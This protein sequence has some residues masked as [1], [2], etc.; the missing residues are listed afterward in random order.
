MG[1]TGTDRGSVSKRERL[2]DIILECEE[3]R[4]AVLAA[5]IVCMGCY[6]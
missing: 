6:L 4:E 1:A 3:R 2:V 5:F